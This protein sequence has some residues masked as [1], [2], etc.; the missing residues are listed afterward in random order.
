[1]RRDHR[2][3][4]S[5]STTHRCERALATLIG[6]IG[7]WRERLV[8]VGGL[9]PRYIVGALPP[10]VNPHV[11]TTDVDLVVQLAV[12][13]DFETY[14]KLA[15]NLRR[16]GFELTQRSYRWV[17]NIEGA[18]IHVEF[19]CE[20]DEVGAGRIH[21]TREN[22]G[23][24]FGAFNVVGAQLVA[25]DYFEYE[26]EADRLDGGGLS[27]VCLQVAGILSYIV[28]KTL[29]FQDRHREKDAYDLVYT[30]VNYPNGG[31]HAAGREAARSLVRQEPLVIEAL[32]LL[33]RCFNNPGHDGPRSY[34]N[35][36]AD[37]DDIDGKARLR[38]EAIAAV[39][40]FLIAA[41]VPEP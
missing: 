7:P 29:A 38:N 1:M 19:L 9:V 4:Y 35:F 25:R 36:Q 16:S 30:L 39:T 40:Q 27:R 3:Q 18:P 23:S 22:T 20:T 24:G 17:R 2:D 31:P 26:I 6:D 37:P 41:D 32:R 33:G 15:A 12:D 13:E 11:G 14:E 28:L 5:E 8:L 10:G 34:A 21:R